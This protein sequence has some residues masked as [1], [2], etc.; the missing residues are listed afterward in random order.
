MSCGIMSRCWPF[1]SSTGSLE[2]SA[3]DATTAGIRE[4][5]QINIITTRKVIG[6][7][8]TDIFSSWFYIKIC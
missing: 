3:S 1:I 4:E 2:K 8:L 6:N 7:A 5:Q